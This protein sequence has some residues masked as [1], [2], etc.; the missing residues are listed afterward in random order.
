MP[1]SNVF[2]KAEGSSPVVTVPQNE[3]DPALESVKYLKIALQ[4]DPARNGIFE[5]DANPRAGASGRDIFV[6]PG[7]LG[8]KYDEHQ[9]AWASPATHWSYRL[10]QLRTP[11]GFLLLGTLASALISASIDGSFA[12]GKIGVLWFLVD[13]AVI[14][15]LSAFSMFCKIVTAVLAFLLAWYFKK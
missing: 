6:Q 3:F 8:L 10:S 15:V 14:D 9:A 13:A 11:N 2:V 4:N 12:L 7:Q 1:E 5:V